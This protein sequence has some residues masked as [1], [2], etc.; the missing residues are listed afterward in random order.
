[1]ATSPIKDALARNPGAKNELIDGFSALA[2][3]SDE[4]LRAFFDSAV[5]EMRRAYT[6]PLSIAWINE[7][8][9]R[10]L[11]NKMD[12]AVINFTVSF[13]VDAYPESAQTPEEFAK[14]LIEFEVEKSPNESRL[15]RVLKAFDAC[16]DEASQAYADI[17]LSTVALPA[18]TAAYVTTDLRISFTGQKI[19]ASVPVALIR[20]HTDEKDELSCQATLSA[21]DE[22]IES[23]SEAR[24]NLIKIKELH[25]QLKTTSE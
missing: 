12:Q 19:K 8:Y 24:N 9:P 1:M 25:E 18:L 5:K 10:S 4:E 3:L 23:L 21:L 7:A 2:E 15:V 20:F 22:V 13:L 16:K 14:S 17:A 11:P 6:F